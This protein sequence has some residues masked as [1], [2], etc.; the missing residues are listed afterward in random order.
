MQWWIPRGLQFPQLYPLEANRVSHE[1]RR[2]TSVIWKNTSSVEP[3]FTRN[4]KLFFRLDTV[5]LSLKILILVALF[6]SVH[7]S[8]RIL[9]STLSPLVNTDTLGSTSEESYSIYSSVSF[10]P[11]LKPDQGNKISGTLLDRWTTEFFQVRH[12]FHI[13]VFH[14]PRLLGRYPPEVPGIE[15]YNCVKHTVSWTVPCGKDLILIAICCFF[16]QELSAKLN[17]TSVFSVIC[18]S[19]LLNSEKWK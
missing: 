3:S 19:V 16:P 10:S 1:Q 17:S 6:F 2:Q 14:F 8:K 9:N 13:H 12:A 18:C 11:S 5:P 15:C 4:P 7:L